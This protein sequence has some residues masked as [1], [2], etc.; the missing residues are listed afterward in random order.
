M[1]HV[2]MCA[3]VFFRCTFVNSELF[4]RQRRRQERNDLE[5]TTML[6]LSAALARLL[7]C[8]TDS[9]QPLCEKESG[10]KVCVCLQVKVGCQSELLCLF[11]FMLSCQDCWGFRFWF[12]ELVRVKGQASLP[13]WHSDCGS[14][15]RFSSCQVQM[16]LRCLFIWGRFVYPTEPA[17]TS[18]EFV[19]REGE[20]G[21]FI[22]TSLYFPKRFQIWTSMSVLFVIRLSEERDFSSLKTIQKCVGCWPLVWFSEVPKIPK[23]IS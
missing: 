3:C 16:L 7:L 8:V 1:V 21:T 5:S 12:S 23:C 10:Q 4:C 9:S 22:F 19:F 20:W 14:P 17:V 6:V 13:T 15:L 11:F 2:C 18:Q